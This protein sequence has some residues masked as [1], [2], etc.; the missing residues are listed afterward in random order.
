VNIGREYFVQDLRTSE[1]PRL[2]LREFS[3]R[4]RQAVSEPRHLKLVQPE[5]E[6]LEKLRRIYLL[7]RRV[8]RDFV[9]EKIAGN[10]CAH[11]GSGC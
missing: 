3:A 9:P 6:L 4:V 2:L 8:V 5:M 7:A 11:V 1:T 10:A